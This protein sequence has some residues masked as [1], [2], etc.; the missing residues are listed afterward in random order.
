MSQDNDESF[1]AMFEKQGA[2]KPA[3]SFR[4]GDRVRAAVVQ[5]G[6]DAVFVELDAKC[7]RSSN[8]PSS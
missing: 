2:P 7:K 1:A 4:V 6:K 3:Q 5:V 8:A